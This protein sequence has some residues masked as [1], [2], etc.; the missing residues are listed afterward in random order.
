MTYS[1]LG[2]AC[3]FGAADAF[4]LQGS[5]SYNASV[6]GTTHK[7]KA[8]MGHHHEALL[9]NRHKARHKVAHMDT[10][11][12]GTDIIHKTAYWGSIRVGTPPQEFK[13][14]FDTGSG[15]LILPTTS[16]T[17]EGCRRHKKYSPTDS[18]SSKSVKNENE[19]ESTEITFG[20]GS[21]TGDFYEDKFCIGD[22]LCSD[23]RFIGSVEQSAAPFSSTPFD[24][25]LG[26]GFKDLSM[27]NKFNIL[28]DMYAAGTLPG[29]Q[30][31]V[32][33]TEDGR[34]EITFGGFREELLASEVVWA[35]VTHESY[36]QVA[37]KDITF[38]N[39]DTQLC[40]AQGCQV[41][42]DTGTSMLA[43]PP[44]LVSALQDKLQAK[45]DCSNFDSLPKI[46]FRV[47]KKILNLAPEDYMD[48]DATGCSFSL[49]P[50]DVP[51]PRGPLFI[52]GDPF[53]R[54]F[55]TIYDKSG[56]Q[57]GFAVAKGFSDASS[58]IVT[59]SEDIGES[60][61][62]RSATHSMM[63][64]GSPTSINLQ[65]GYM[66]DDQQQDSSSTSDDSDKPVAP[67]P[68]HRTKSSENSSPFSDDDADDWMKKFSHEL[69]K[70]RAPP[71]AAD[72][73][74]D[75]LTKPSAPPSAA[76]HEGPLKAN[77]YFDDDKEDFL[78]MY[79]RGGESHS[80]PASTRTSSDDTSS[81]ASGTA[82][83]E[84]TLVWP[85][86]PSPYLHK[87]KSEEPEKREESSSAW[88]ARMKHLLDGD[89]VQ[90][91]KGNFLQKTSGH[92][93]SAAQQH[94]RKKLAGPQLVSV[95]LHKA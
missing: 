14:I 57:V 30:F 32:F 42:V 60:Y 64:T 44:A 15:N 68:P 74:S 63:E 82:E 38:D 40:G 91:S 9:F 52:F 28:D 6:K 22:G 77:S 90:K 76:D 73:G 33:L 62:P 94:A 25:I 71:S 93:A 17:S 36:W 2:V 78:N 89:F 5:N 23:I 86:W 48:R 37:V 53:L 20:T 80:S 7:S 88:A 85:S 56:P 87:S 26:L 81:T 59:S 16:C 13:V 34:S 12:F 67:A 84:S 3:L 1:F 54:R 92:Q 35:P 8:K 45:D 58:F 55:V 70:P 72:A 18:S 11:A 27:G 10:N 65:A 49:M 83:K 79:L 41:A 4:L 95:K 47:G 69:T 19:E 24:G 21:I 39:T 51:P 31:S 66:S 61:E 50:L 46:G 29:G 75:V 43:G